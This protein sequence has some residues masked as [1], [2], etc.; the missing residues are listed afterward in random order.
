MC[1]RG[2]YHLLPI[3]ADQE[4]S[5]LESGSLRIRENSDLTQLDAL[6]LS[7]IIITMQMVTMMIV[8]RTLIVMGILMMMM[9]V[10]RTLM[11]MLIVIFV[12]VFLL[13]PVVC[14]SFRP[15]A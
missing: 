10:M 2:R 11:M 8:M 4:I 14:G 7:I 5:V 12:G 6:N 15:K 3:D 13:Q 9:I 1:K